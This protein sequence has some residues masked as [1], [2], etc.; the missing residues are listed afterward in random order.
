MSDGPAL[1]GE[2]GTAALGPLTGPPTLYGRVQRVVDPATVVVQ[3]FSA[4]PGR[5]SF[6]LDSVLSV[7][8]DEDTVYADVKATLVWVDSRTGRPTPLPDVIRDALSA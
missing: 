7:E 6:P 5:T 3:V 8:G 4:G 1:A 2:P